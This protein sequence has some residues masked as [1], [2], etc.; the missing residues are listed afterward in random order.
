MSVLIPSSSLPNS[1]YYIPE[2]LLPEPSG[3]EYW[4]EDLAKKFITEQV[5]KSKKILTV[6]QQA[7]IK[8]WLLYPNRIFQD[9]EPVVQQKFTN[10]KV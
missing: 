1:R 9:P 3:L 2:T 8:D 4:T 7:N 6:Q 5:P 10:N